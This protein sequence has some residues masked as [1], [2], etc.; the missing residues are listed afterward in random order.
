MQS[1]ARGLEV[2]RSFS[3]AAPRQTLTEVARPHRPHARRRAPHPADAADAGLRRE[4][5]PAVPLTPRI[6][7]LGFAYLSSMPM[8]NLAEPVME[9]LV[10]QV[11]GVVLGRRAG[12]HGHRLRAARVH[13]QDHA[14]QPGRGLA[15]A[16]LLHLDGPRA[17][18][19]VCPTTRCCALL[20]AAR[21]QART[22]HTLTDPE[23]VLAKVQQARRQGWCLV[24][25]ELE[26]GLISI[27]AP[28]SNRAGRTVAALN[29]SGQANRTTP[30]R[31]QETMLPPLRQRP[32][33]SRA[34]WRGPGPRR[35]DTP[36]VH[37]GGGPVGSMLRAH[38]PNP[39]HPEIVSGVRCG[40]SSCTAS[41][42]P[43]ST[44]PARSATQ[45]G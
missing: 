34:G 14:Q 40:R 1:F 2:I 38:L 21:S 25:Q 30:R 12:R 27:A 13:A 28:M 17:A 36:R 8:W 15:P 44:S 5:R 42:P 4:R 33:T 9:A 18:G 32:R 43:T 35:V 11:Q 22:R 10:D 20:Q 6:L 16:G 19:R 7:D 37:H 24:N 31:M 29:I 23:A 39:H 3:A 41:T 45:L 26:E